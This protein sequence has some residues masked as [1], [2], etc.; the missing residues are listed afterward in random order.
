M[1]MGLQYR[2][3]ILALMS[4]VS[5]FCKKDK[6]KDCLEVTLKNKLF[7]HIYFTG[8][9][10]QLENNRHTRVDQSYN[11]P[12]LST[13]I[14]LIQFSPLK[15][16]ANPIDHAIIIKKSKDGYLFSYTKYFF[17][18]SCTTYIFLRINVLR[19]LT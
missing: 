14:L 2:K 7:I 8:V 11:M 3:S 4:V 6:V 16:F 10:V 17:C 1:V 13:L 19:I 15:H 18:F 5:K 9:R 12:N